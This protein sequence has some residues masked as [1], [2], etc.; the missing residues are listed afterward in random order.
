MSTNCLHLAVGR[1][2][3]LNIL[4]LVTLGWYWVGTGIALP[5]PPV[6]PLPRVHLPPVHL[7]HGRTAVRVS[8]E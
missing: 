8:L 2:Y 1:A 3:I 7:R 4:Y 5:Q 6:I